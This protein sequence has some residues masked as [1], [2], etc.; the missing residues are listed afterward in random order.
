MLTFLK[1]S[2]FLSPLT[3]LRSLFLVPSKTFTFASK[4]SPIRFNSRRTHHLYQPKVTTL[5]FVLVRV[6]TLK[7]TPS[8]SLVHH[9]KYKALV[10]NNTT[11]LMLV[12][13]SL[14]Q[15]ANT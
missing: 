11:R 5:K 13:L 3:V 12:S 10:L 6:I 8:L 7:L 1:L 4:H 15:M 14:Q 2:F 9:D